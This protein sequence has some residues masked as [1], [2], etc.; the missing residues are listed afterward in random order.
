MVMMVMAGMAQRRHLQLI[1]NR[2]W[3]RG[4]RQKAGILDD[5]SGNSKTRQIAAPYPLEVE[6]NTGMLRPIHWMQ[7]EKGAGKA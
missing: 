4:Q 3:R 7:A 1:L 6:S 5:F 2:E